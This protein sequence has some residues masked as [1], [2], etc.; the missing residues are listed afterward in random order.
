MLGHLSLD[1]DALVKGETFEEQ[2]VERI[3]LV[4]V[5]VMVA[6]EETIRQV[7]V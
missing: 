7:S 4:A 3:D 5:M 1:L 2:E 6:R